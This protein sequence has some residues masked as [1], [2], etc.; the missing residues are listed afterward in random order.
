MTERPW[1][2]AVLGVGDVVVH[3]LWSKIRFLVLGFSSWPSLAGF[4]ALQRDGL[5]VF[6]R[7][8]IV[9]CLQS[10]LTFIKPYKTGD[11][12]YLLKVQIKRLDPSLN[13]AP[14]LNLLKISEEAV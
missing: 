14:L 8:G 10:M 9:W 11:F 4:V 1:N 2:K 3:A 6:D 12:G 7:P 5:G 13:T